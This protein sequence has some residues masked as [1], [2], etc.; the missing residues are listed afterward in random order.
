MYIISAKIRGENMQYRG[1]R[2]RGGRFS[3]NRLLVN[4]NCAPNDQSNQGY[5]RT[6][7]TYRHQAQ[8][9]RKDY[10]REIIMIRY[11]PAEEKVSIEILEV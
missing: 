1:H 10:S 9:I 2:M 5:N 6:Q 3:V 8:Q 7:N 11:T 4:R